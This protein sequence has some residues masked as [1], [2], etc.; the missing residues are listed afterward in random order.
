MMGGIFTL[1]SAM[2]VGPIPPLRPN[3]ENSE[4]Y[5]TI[6]LMVFWFGLI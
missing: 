1:I 3:K 6:A 4:Y 2:Y 5:A